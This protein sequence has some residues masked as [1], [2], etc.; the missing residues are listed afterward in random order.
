MMVTTFEHAPAQGTIW[1]SAEDF[2]SASILY[3]AI[4]AV[5]NKLRLKAMDNDRSLAGSYSN[6]KP[7]DNGKLLDALMNL[8]EKFTVA[9]GRKEDRRIVWLCSRRR[10]YFQQESCSQIL[11]LDSLEQ[12][13]DRYI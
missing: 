3:S 5:H 9:S 2:R 4:C 13:L 7:G 12:G 1:A 10:H 8:P 11:L 6:R